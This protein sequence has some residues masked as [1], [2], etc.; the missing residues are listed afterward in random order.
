[1][2]PR[3]DQDSGSLDTYNFLK[4]FKNLDFHVTFIPSDL[5]FSGHYTE[6][7]QQAGVKCI[8]K[9]LFSSLPRAI[10]YFASSADIVLL[11][12]ASI[13]YPLVPTIRKYAP[14]AKLIFDAVDL[15]YL[16]KE[17]QASISRSFIKF[18]AA[19]RMQHI[20]LNVIKNVDATILLSS[21][22]LNLIKNQVPEARLFHIP[23]VRDIPTSFGKS[24]EQRRDLVFIGGYQHPPNIDAVMFFVN[25]VWPILRASGFPGR[26]IIAGSDMPVH[27]QKLAA[28]DIIIRG[29]V[30]DLSDL[31]GNCRF[32]VAPLRYGAGM[33]GKIISSLSHGLPCIATSNAIEGTGLVNGENI[34]VEDDPFKLATLI[35]E[36][37][38][39]KNL[40]EK[41][42]Q[43]GLHHCAQNC[44]I[45]AVTKQIEFMLSELLKS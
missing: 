15:H 19:K 24:W 18:L 12:R 21:Y 44:S 3:P 1:M 9:P 23:V 4:I 41:L 17:R 22:E 25:K 35:Q 2:T 39:K 10:K 28:D 32:S 34:L 14:R 45:N 27:F 42:S 29:Y 6:C 33:K 37:Y 5:K 26:F 40:W 20:E 13:A 30:S 11:Y 43:A 8:H 31:F 38:D 16:R 36:A 7:L